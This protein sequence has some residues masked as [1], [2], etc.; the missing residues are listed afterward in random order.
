MTRIALVAHQLDPAMATGI[1]R[2]TRG[3]AHGLEP[4][5]S[6]SGDDLVVVTARGCGTVPQRHRE[7]AVKR[8]HL[9]AGWHFLGLPLVEWLVRDLD[10]VHVSAPVVR[11]PTRLPLVVTIHDVLPLT[12]PQ[13]YSPREIKLFSQC[14]EWIDRKAAAVVLP[15]QTIADDVVRTTSIGAGRLCVTGEGVELDHFRSVA[16]SSVVADCRLVE[17]DYLLYLG[18][19]S[20]RKNVARLVEAAEGC[21]WPLVIVGPDGFGAEQV[22][23]A[24]AASPHDIRL[25]GRLSDAEVGALVRGARALVHPSLYEGFGLTVVEAMAVGTPV[26]VSGA[27]S[28]PEVVG[29]G[30]LVVTEDSSDA[31]KSALSQLSK[32]ETLESL[33]RAGLERARRWTWEEAASRT[34]ALYREVL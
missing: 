1:A 31:W 24:I 14:M 18:Q 29:S 32:P 6:V 12:H 27:G 7:I 4:L 15:T 25:L 9:Y 10:L 23:D 21:P 28:L 13:W 8:R 34:L 3:L 30:G 11:V 17:G 33:R 16:K 19:V 20:T 26:V 22:H 5:M 2:Y